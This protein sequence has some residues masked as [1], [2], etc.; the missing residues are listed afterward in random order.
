MQNTKLSENCFRNNIQQTIF[1]KA[2][3][4]GG[5]KNCSMKHTKNRDS[6]NIPFYRFFQHYWTCRAPPLYVSAVQKTKN[7]KRSMKN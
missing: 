4:F 7:D 1:L 3:H 6:L 5:F 2:R